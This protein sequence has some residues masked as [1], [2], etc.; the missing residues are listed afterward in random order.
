MER[1]EEIGEW[2]SSS[3]SRRRQAS[4]QGWREGDDNAAFEMKDF[5]F[6][7][8]VWPW[9][10]GLRCV[11]EAATTPRESLPASDNSTRKN[12]EMCASS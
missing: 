6:G 12:P 10:S 2:E 1:E 11:E 9:R 7:H 3:R 4:D 8:T 5:D